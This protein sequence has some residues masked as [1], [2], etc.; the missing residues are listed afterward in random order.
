MTVGFIPFGGFTPGEQYYLSETTA[1]TFT[2]T[3]PLP[4]N[5]LVPIFQSHSP[6]SIFVHVQ[7][8]QSAGV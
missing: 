4:P 8:G 6:T 3:P 1:G 7:F 2:T 5:F